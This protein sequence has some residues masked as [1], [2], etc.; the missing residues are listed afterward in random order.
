MFFKD[1]NLSTSNDKSNLENP[2]EKENLHFIDNKT[3]EV[4]NLNNED[5]EDRK[6][7][8]SENFKCNFLS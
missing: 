1:F 2:F 7:Y 4:S 6:I 3:S 5:Y 8:I